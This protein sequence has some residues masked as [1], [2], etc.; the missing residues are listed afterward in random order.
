MESL[1]SSVLRAAVA[2]LMQAVGGTDGQSSDVTDMEIMQAVVTENEE[3]IN[4]YLQKSAN[5]NR[6]ITILGHGLSPLHLACRLGK[7]RVLDLFVAAHVD[8]NLQNANGCSLLYMASL[9][10]REQIVDSLIKAQADVNLQENVAGTFPLFVAAQEGYKTVV[11]LLIK[12]QADVNLQPSNGETALYSASE[13]GHYRVVDSLIEAQADVNLQQADGCPP[14]FIASQNGHQRVVDSLINAGADV[15]LQ[16]SIGESSLYIAS[17]NGDCR[18]VDSLIKAQADVNI[19]RRTGESSLLIASQNGHQAVIDSLVKA[20]ADVNLQRSTGD[21]PLIVAASRGHQQIVDSLIKAGADVNLQQNQGGSPL[22]AASQNGHQKVVASLIKAQADVNLQRDMG[23][24]PLFIASQTGHQQI[25]E[26]LIRAQADVSLQ[27]HTG[28]SPLYI[29]SQNGDLAMVDSLIEAQADVNLQQNQGGSPLYIAS[30]LGHQEVVGSLIK[31]QANVNLKRNSGQSPIY[32]ASQ[33]GRVNVVN[34]LIRARADYNVEEGAADSPLYIAVQNGHQDVVLTLTKAYYEYDNDL[35]SEKLTWQ[36]EPAI[37]DRQA[38]LNDPELSEDLHS[39]MTKSGFVESR[40]ALQIAAADTLQEIM[41]E[42]VGDSDI[43]VV[44]SYSEGWGNSLKTLDGRTDIESDIDV[45]KLIPGRLYHP[46]GLCECAEESAQHE[47]SNGHIWCPG[48]ASKPAIATEGSALK[49]ATDD[50]SASRLCCY[51]PIAPLQPERLESSNIPKPLLEALHRVTT[52]DSTPCHV[53]HAASPGRGGQELRVSTSFLEKRMLRSLT[54]L[55]GQ[56]FVTLKYLVK[57][58]ICS[59][60]GFNQQGL[61]SYHVKSITFRMVEETPV[62][63]WKTENLVSLVRRSLQMLLGCVESSR[64]PYNAHGRIMEHFFLSDVAVY[65]KG[66]V[67]KDGSM[68]QTLGSIASTLRTVI[69][70]LPQLLQQFMSSLRP[71][72]DSGIFYFH[73]FQILPDLRPRA[74]PP[75]PDSLE[76]HVICDVVRECLVRLSRGDCSPQSQESLTELIA[77]LPDCARSAREALRALA[78]LKFGYR[79]TA[80]RIV[81]QCRGLSVSRGMAWSA[82]RSATEATTEFVWRHLRSRDSAWKFCFRFEKRPEFAFLARAVQEIFP[83]NVGNYPQVF[84]IN[85]D[86][87]L[88][89]LCDE[90]DARGG[91]FVASRIQGMAQREDADEQELQVGI[92]LSMDFTEATALME[93]LAGLTGGI[94]SWLRDELHKK[95]LPT[96]VADLQLQ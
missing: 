59:K 54:T 76:Y 27:R 91:S 32:I 74:P 26:S 86:A 60:D 22:F 41:R 13:H 94:P 1:C 38:V 35:S 43:F 15:N 77:R 83:Q 73:P 19:Q 57:K 40:A 47:M 6:L 55:Q 48:F 7:Q 92:L 23:E 42:R 80:E 2:V 33:N 67:G 3:V 72:S 70:R 51:P 81:S 63:Q 96:G 44:G 62:E 5:V 29:A 49:P 12:A 50:V 84:F 34:S 21:S 79:G 82:E 14:L 78:C 95:W 39:A 61:K 37:S 65:L 52:S 28:E 75:Q 16:G 8:V 69:D 10:G 56:L 45:M 93:R 68:G 11:D 4:R 24:S 30:Q 25:V 31:A 89:A 64:S 9:H 71:V 46:R 88:L 87:L 17:Q 90:L 18:I 53:V 36:T 66:A 58:V 85:F 20:Q